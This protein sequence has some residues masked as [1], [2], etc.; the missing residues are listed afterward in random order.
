MTQAVDTLV[1]KINNPVL[2]HS[3]VNYVHA[4]ALLHIPHI[5]VLEQGEESLPKIGLIFRKRVYLTRNIALFMM[6]HYIMKRRILDYVA[7]EISVR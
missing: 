5:C 3:T 7:K 6:S 2:F 1:K 4:G